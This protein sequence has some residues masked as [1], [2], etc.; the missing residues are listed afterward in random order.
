MKGR[1]EQAASKRK[2]PIKC[3]PAK[4]FPHKERPTGHF[5]RAF[6]IPHLGQKNSTQAT[7]GGIRILQLSPKGAYGRVRIVTAQQRGCSRHTKSPM[8]RHNLP[9]SKRQGEATT[10]RKT[11]ATRSTAAFE[12]HRIEPKASLRSPTPGRSCASEAP[13]VRL[14]RGPFPR[15]A[16][17]RPESRAVARKSYATHPIPKRAASLTLPSCPLRKARCRDSYRPPSSH[18]TG[19]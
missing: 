8:P 7:P 13:R 14:W 2:R 10:R 3:A 6:P 19:S 1:P 11:K 15:R 4:D 9:A 17:N 16:R 5:A 18:S 12:E